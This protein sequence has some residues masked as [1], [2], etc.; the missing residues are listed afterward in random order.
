MN[1]QN[2]DVRLAVLERDMTQMQGALV[3][4][5]D[6]LSRLVALEERHAETRESVGRAFNQV[7]EIDDRVSQI[8]HV[9]PQLIETRSWVLAM[10]GFV[11]AAVITGVLA[12]VLK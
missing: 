6:S 9:L 5:S 11:L 10:F 7:G 1:Q 3:S 2:P 12:L 8:E 4:I